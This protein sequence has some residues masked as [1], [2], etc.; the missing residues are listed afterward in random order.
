MCL[1]SINHN[2]SLATFVNVILYD[3]CFCDQIRLL[4]FYA[5]R[6]QLEND[7]AKGLA[8]LHARLSKA[9]IGLSGY[10]SGHFSKLVIFKRFFG[11]FC[12]A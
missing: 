7:Y 8:K 3:L 6:I 4:L 5:Q 12:A 2:A 9:A 11:W 10:V 1:T